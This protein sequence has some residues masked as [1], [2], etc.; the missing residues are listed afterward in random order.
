MSFGRQS[1]RKSRL[2]ATCVML[3]VALTPQVQ[4]QTG[5]EVVA[6][7]GALS[8]SVIAAGNRGGNVELTAI[9][10]Q[11]R[12]IEAIHSRLDEI[13]SSLGSILIAL[14]TLK[15]D[16]RDLLDQDRDK[17]RME[18]VYGKITV[19]RQLIDDL[20]DA[21]KQR[22]A[23]QII[24]LN[25]QL[26]YRLW[27]FR[28]ERAALEQR[29]DFVLPMLVSAM[30]TEIGADDAVKAPRKD[31][32][33]A[34]NDYDARL[35]KMQDPA[36][37]GSIVSLRKQLGDQHQSTGAKIAAQVQKTPGAKPA[38]GA[39][40]QKQEVLTV[41]RYPW[42]SHTLQR[43]ED[44]W[45]TGIC[46]RQNP[47]QMRFEFPYEEGSTS[48]LQIRFE[49]PYE[50]G[51]TSLLQKI[52]CDTK[53]TV[54]IDVHSRQWFRTIALKPIQDSSIPGLLELSV[55]PDDPQTTS[56]G[57]PG[58]QRHTIS[59]ADYEAVFLKQEVELNRQIDQYNNEAKAI[60]ELMRLEALIS[61]A[62]ATIV[63]WTGAR[64]ALLDKEAAH[65]GTSADAALDKLQQTMAKNAALDHIA[66]QTKAREQAWKTIIEARQ[67][68]DAAIQRARR[69]SWRGEIVGLLNVLQ[70]SLRTYVAVD[71][72]LAAADAARAVADATGS[73]HQ[74]Q[75][76]TAPESK[77]NPQSEEPRAPG[78]NNASPP[79]Q[80]PDHKPQSPIPDAAGPLRSQ[81]AD[82]A[83]VK[84]VEQIL[85][86]ASAN[87]PR[88]WETL[89]PELTP[90]EIALV[91]AI[92]DLDK[93]EP[94]AAD[95][96]AGEEGVTPGK[97]IG[98]ALSGAAGEGVEGALNELEPISKL[99]TGHDQ[100]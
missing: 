83:R 22:D 14:A 98:D 89:P 67:E 86:E 90:Q 100:L 82:L 64:V 53:E 56:G 71:K 5:V 61:S 36:R 3:S 12:I 60:A 66:A 28:E 11:T 2:L 6:A 39:P 29:S 75:S 44:R 49:F 4:A 68:V 76:S 58:A 99:L 87:P 19:L 77:K 13:E 59:D 15:K 9:L 65:L 38:A 21:V 69:D 18:T 80:G 8:S 10:A 57:I 79:A 63:R 30:L 17:V 25:T 70:A 91:E 72:A 32:A 45:K 54:G 93:M 42:F 16:V 26:N 1:L 55:Q 73:Q 46:H 92:S 7:V 34:L 88:N 47:H 51:S 20:S 78:R 94:T 40:V 85:K 24:A 31:R 48:L 41:G 96:F 52:D 84:R 35:A 95:V 81:E 33:R 50:E 23:S 62:R 43:T 74:K 97:A 27:N 37:Q